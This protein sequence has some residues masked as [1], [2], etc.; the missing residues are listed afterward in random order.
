MKTL[1]DHVILYDKECP[2]C[3]LYTEAF[4]S[5]GMLDQNG[6]LAFNEANSMI[7]QYGVDRAK[8]CDEIALVNVKTGRVEYGIES[9]MHIFK[10]RFPLF[11][12]LF[13]SQSFTFLMSKLYAFI[14]F[15]RKVIIPGKD[16]EM[17]G[18]CRPAF[19]LN[20]RIAYLLFTGL[21]TSLILAN[22]SALLFPLIPATNFYR[23]FLICGGQILFQGIIISIIDRSKTFEYLGNMMT[24]SFA[25]GL[26]LAI[27]MLF[28]FTS[29]IFAGIFVI[30]VALMFLEHIR[31]TKLL[32]L[33]WLMTFSWIVYRILILALLLK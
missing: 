33:P 30:V 2:M 32:K 26:L 5:T 21:I 25:A 24:I 29:I 6:K 23:E 8:A 27:M 4:V 22:Y 28:N 9:L 12:A 10:N 16:L 31:R 3:N 11:E 7:N 14:S 17:T 18:A 1:H 13:T 15:N 20:Y 19:N